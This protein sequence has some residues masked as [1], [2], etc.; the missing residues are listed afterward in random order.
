MKKIITAITTLGLSLS[1]VGSAGAAGG[2][3]FEGV[4]TSTSKE[5]ISI[6]NVQKP[7]TQYRYYLKKDYSTGELPKSIT[8]SD[9]NGYYGTLK[10]VSISTY[11][12]YKE[13]WKVEFYGIVTKA[14]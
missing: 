1:I 8:Y 6:L 5:S 10:Q 3:T 11:G 13:Y 2:A 9:A 7:M 4:P 14:N 12:T